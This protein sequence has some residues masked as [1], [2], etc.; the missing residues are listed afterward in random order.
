MIHNL[1]VSAIIPIKEHSERV[2]DKNFRSFIDKPLYHHILET[3]ENTYAIDEII[4]DTDSKLV[5][6]EAPSKFSKVRIINRLPELCGDLVSVNKIIEYDLTKTE[7][8]IFIQTHATNPLL[9][10]ETIAKALKMFLE[11]ENKYDS[12]FSVNRFQSRFYNHNGEPV[13]HNQE[14]LIRTQDL[15]PLFE[16]NSNFYLFTKQSFKDTNRRIGKKPLLFEMSKI[17]S[18]DIDDEF[19]FRLAEILA[20][21]A[22]SKF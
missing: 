1:K 3:L 22:K 15:N 20:L 8:D 13:N 10:A 11:T 14:E 19:S 18:I 7:S 9:K 21:Y 17:E 5:A 4:I 6:L 2:K 12:V 16:E